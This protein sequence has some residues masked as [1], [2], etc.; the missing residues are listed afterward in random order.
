MTEPFTVPG[1]G[2]EPRARCR[3][4]LSRERD[5]GNSGIQEFRNSCPCGLLVSRAESREVACSEP[6]L[7]I[8]AA[9]QSARPT[10]RPC[11][12]PHWTGK[13]ACLVS[14]GEVEAGALDEKLMYQHATH[15]Q[16]TAPCHGCP[17]VRFSLP[18]SGYTPRPRV[19]AQKRILSSVPIIAR[20]AEGV[21]QRDVS[22]AARLETETGNRHSDSRRACSRGVH[23]GAGN[24][25]LGHR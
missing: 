3:N 15:L 11:H 21:S 20:Y 13:L 2:A 18:R 25:R 7:A 6:D 4:A 12:A 8:D 17:L 5:Q 14:A 10:S 16:G 23:A 24:Q 9:R 19:A 1:Y 22:D